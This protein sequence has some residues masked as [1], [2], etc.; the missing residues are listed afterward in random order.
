MPAV[1]ILASRPKVIVTETLDSPVGPLMAAATDDGICMLEFAG[2]RT[3][4][5]TEAISRCFGAEVMDGEHRYLDQ[6]EA[7]SREYFAGERREFTV[8]LVIRGTPFPGG[9]WR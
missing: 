4:M 6:L 8:P 3:E 2:P 5:Q 7:E 1:S 9:L